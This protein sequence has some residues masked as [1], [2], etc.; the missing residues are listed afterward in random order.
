MS[1]RQKRVSQHPSAK[2]LLP[3]GTP[4][5]F[6]TP[7]L[8]VAYGGTHVSV[9]ALPWRYNAFLPDNRDPYPNWSQGA[10]SLFRVFPPPALRPFIPADIVRTNRAFLDKQVAGIR[11]H[12]LRLCV[13]GHEPNWLPEA[14]FRAHPRWRGSQVELGRIAAKPYFVPSIDEPEVLDLYRWSVR[15]LCR[16]YPECDFIS[17]W[18]NDCGSGIPWSVY[19]YPGMNGPLK[20]RRRDPGERVC[21]WM[22]AMQ[23]GATD[24]GATVAINVHSFSFPP[25]DAAAIRARLGRQFYLNGANGE[26]QSLIGAS[27]SLAADAAVMPV[28]G[29]YNPLS[30]VR[31]L[32]EVFRQAGR[33]GLRTISIEDTPAHVGQ[34]LLQAFLAAPGA[35]L[36][37]AAR[38]VED[39]AVALAGPAHAE[40]VTAAWEAVAQACHCVRQVRQ[41]GLGLAV[42]FGL[43][44]SRWLIRPLVPQPL[45]LTAAEEAHYRKFLF[46]T[47]TREQDADLCYVLGKPVF[48]GDGVM[49]MTR[50]CL[51]EAVDHL[52][53]AQARLTGV[54]AA[55]KT[56]PAHAELAAYGARVGAY[57]CAL[58]NARLTIMY[59]H[60][61]N[62]AD[63]PR[64]GSNPLDFDDNILYD[65]R[66]L[67]M[68]KIARADLDNTQEL[69]E[70]LEANRGVP[71]F[72][73]GKTDAEETVFIFGPK[74]IR[75]LRR[76]MEVMLD[77]WHDYERL[78]PTSKVHEY[79]PREPEQGGAVGVHGAVPKQPLDQTLSRP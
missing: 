53:A 22:A 8:A 29:L 5:V 47:G 42:P 37:Q 45:A 55:V 61:L 15:E 6:N 58:E 78:Y 43:T 73:Q 39:L 10:F 52:R 68:R 34:Q 70:L 25:G 38:L 60:A 12:G 50:W 63:Q 41:R 56:E 75:Q 1:L 79:E 2:N 46:S 28:I 31:G 4:V 49:W 66:A 16:V 24:A 44:N 20:H 51:Q 32:Q 35:G 13:H 9:G 17:F 40:A 11:R 77:H 18:T 36:A 74:L 14:V 76:K 65:Q 7:E 3:A 19:G 54:V 64:F 67:E 21:N 30:F 62:I 27:A 69:I 48:R 72:N 71:L 33:P 23:A 57:A 26:G 59:Q